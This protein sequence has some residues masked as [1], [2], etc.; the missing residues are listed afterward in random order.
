MRKYEY[1]L[2][3]LDGT[4]TYSHPGIYAGLRYALASLGRPEPDER[5]LRLCVGP[6][7]TYSFSEIFGL[8]EAQTAEAVQKYREYYAEKGLFEN[9]PVPGA[10]KALEELRRRG[11]R[12]ALATSKPEIFARRVSD[13]FGFS[14]FF[15]A[16]TGSGTDGSLPSKADVI[17]E[18]LRRLN[19][20]NNLSLMVGDRKHDAEGARLCKVDF[21][22]FTAGYAEE[23]ELEAEHPVFLFGTFAGLTD[24]L[25]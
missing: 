20:Q 1:V 10:K 19:A 6:P 4:L 11:Y 8:S 23:G 3:D 2:F 22:G 18:A 21:A 24:W 9:E 15:D 7:L 17:R 16:L 5:Q 12:L 25:G 13:A 14:P